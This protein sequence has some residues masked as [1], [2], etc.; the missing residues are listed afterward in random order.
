MISRPVESSLVHVYNSSGSCFISSPPHF[1]IRLYFPQG[2]IVTIKPEECICLS[3]LRPVPSYPVSTPRL[4]RLTRQSSTSRPTASSGPK[5]SSPRHLS[6]TPVRK[7]CPRRPTRP[8]LSST[9]QPCTS[10][11]WSANQDGKRWPEAQDRCRSSKRRRFPSLHAVSRGEPGN[12]I[13]DRELRMRQTSSPWRLPLDFRIKA[14]IQ[15]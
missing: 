11:S 13:E 12:A 10:S 5:P 4:I 7:S 3:V 14:R 2:T 9:A 8:Y 15:K 6:T 1:P